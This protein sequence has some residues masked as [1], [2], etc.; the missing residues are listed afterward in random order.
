LAIAQQ[1][2][3]ELATSATVNTLDIDGGTRLL[4]DT[5]ITLHME[6]LATVSSGGELDADGAVSVETA[7]LGVDGT[8]NSFGQFTPVGTVIVGQGGALVASG[9]MTVA[10]G[11][12][13]TLGTVTVQGICQI[14]APGGIEVYSGGTLD[15]QGTVTITTTSTENL[16]IDQGTVAVDRNA[17]LDDQGFVDVT[18]Q[19]TISDAGTMKGAGTVTVSTLS[20]SL[21]LSPG[22][23][24]NDWQGTV[25]VTNHGT[26][27]NQGGTITV[28]ASALLSVDGGYLGVEP[29]GSLDD[30][31]TVALTAQ[32][33]LEDQQATVTVESNASLTVDAQSTV[34]VAGDQSTPA[35]LFVWGTMDVSGTLADASPL[36]VIVGTG[37][38]LTVHDLGKATVYGGCTLDD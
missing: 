14:L 15:D 12:V 2:A 36:G 18:G 38:M 7:Y 8:I 1:G 21:I 24:L 13:T 23:T 27:D 34:E 16:L 6:G 19:F 33:Y 9:T 26:L 28:A 4:L 31:G 11:S 37:G 30:R 35:S 10:S 22:S 32:G 3:L 29:G 20:G 17:S 25:K 5:G